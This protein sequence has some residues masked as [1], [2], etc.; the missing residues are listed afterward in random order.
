MVNHCQQPPFW[1]GGHSGRNLSASQASG[2]SLVQSPLPLS[3]SSLL[4]P[5]WSLWWRRGCQPITSGS[6]G[7]Q[8]ASQMSEH[9]WIK[10]CV[11]TIN[12]CFILVEENFFYA[13]FTPIWASES[14][15]YCGIECV[16]HSCEFSE[17]A[18]YLITPISIHIPTIMPVLTLH[19]TQS[20]TSQYSVH[21]LLVLILMPRLIGASIPK[22]TLLVLW[23][24]GGAPSKLPH[25]S[26]A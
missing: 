2:V 24:A 13:L 14:K 26:I 10:H 17:P 19:D 6:S 7:K 18:P 12:K 25:Q 11:R 5:H 16:E 9:S 20:G 1:W 23:L 4:T 3:K 8:I 15:K 21:A 22:L